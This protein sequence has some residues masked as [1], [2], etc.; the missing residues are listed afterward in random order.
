VIVKVL[1][2][3]LGVALIFLFFVVAVRTWG[4]FLVYSVFLNI[5]VAFGFACSVFVITTW[6]PR[7]VRAK[8]RGRLNVSNLAVVDWATLAYL[9]AIVFGIRIVLTLMEGTPVPT[10][11]PRAILNLAI[12]ILVAFKLGLRAHIWLRALRR[13]PDAIDDVTDQ[14]RTP[15]KVAEEH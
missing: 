15:A 1:R 13:G 11:L 9:G 12:W 8:R 2:A 14:V 4:G 6:T 3:T 10:S 5:L 7:I